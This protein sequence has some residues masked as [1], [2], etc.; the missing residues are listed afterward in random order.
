MLRPR[1]RR[2]EVG[3]RRLPGQGAGRSPQ[4][5]PLSDHVDPFFGDRLR[6]R[7][8]RPRQGQRNVIKDSIAVA[9]NAA[10]AGWP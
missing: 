6:C 4:W 8:L 9:I 1:Q 2:N 5:Y 3:R 10:N 7:I